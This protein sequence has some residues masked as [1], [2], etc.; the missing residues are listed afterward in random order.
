MKIAAVAI[1]GAA[2]SITLKKSAPETALL[3]AAALAAMCIGPLYSAFKTI[4]DLIGT[5]RETAGVDQAVVSPLLKT[6]GV[7]IICRLASDMCKDASQQALASA[8]EI[9][10][11]VTV[12]FLSIPLINSALGLVSSLL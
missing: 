10:G 9:A 7:S 11:A 12:V 1:I 2:L 8:V 4:I 6:V 3:L 5:L